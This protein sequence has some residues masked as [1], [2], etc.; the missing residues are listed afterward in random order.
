MVEAIRDLP[1]IKLERQCGYRLVNSKYPPIDLFDDVADPDEFEALYALQAMTNPRLQ[2]E[3][4]QLNLL[5]REEI[6]FGIRGCSYATAPFTHVNP[7]GSR[8]SNGQ[9][10][11]LYIADTMDTA[12][13]E[14]A[15]HQERYWKNVAG[16][17][18]DRL[19]FRGLACE[20]SGDPIHDATVLPPDHPI[21][22]PEDYSAA[23]ALGLKLRKAKST[24]IQYHSVRNPGGVCWGL[25]TPRFVH[26][27]VQTAHYELIWNN[28]AIQSISQ[29]VLSKVS[30]A[31]MIVVCEDKLPSRTGDTDPS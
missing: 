29:L 15:Y 13:R 4:G 2:T 10:G 17:K 9:Y 11:V 1:R 28:S 3:L 23:Q 21:Y 30:D 22:D 14:V 24:G 12:L 25:F 27:I 31:G 16:L 7:D 20:F 6:P 26:S 19:V 18:Y 5:A 8:F